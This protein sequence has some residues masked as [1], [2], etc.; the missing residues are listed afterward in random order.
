M[1]LA[2]LSVRTRLIALLGLLSLALFG[3]VLYSWHALALSGDRLTAALKL[4]ND[5]EQAVNLSRKAQVDFKI[6]VQE[7]KDLL[8][9]GGDAQDYDKYSQAFEATA[10]TVTEDFQQLAPLMT[11]I[12]LDTKGIDKAVLEHDL[13]LKKYKDA[14]KSYDRA[15]PARTTTV[16]RMVRGIDR[17]PTGNIDAIV[18]QIRERSDGLSVE[19]VKAAAAE[20]RLQVIW[21]L[22]VAIVA[23]AVSLSLGWYI[24][25]GIVTPLQ[26]ATA[27]AERVA[28]GDLTSHIQPSGS[29]ET[30]RLLQA[31]A[32]M[33]RSLSAM[34]S[35]VRLGANAVTTASTEI[36]A[37]NLDLSSRT[38]QQA[39][40]IEETAASLEELT[41]TVTQNAG[42][43]RE[44]EK[45]AGAA[46]TI[47]NRGGA[48]VNEVVRTMDDIQNSSKKISEIIGVIDS[49]AFQT[50]ILALNAA[51]EAARAGEQGRG[52]AVVATEVRGL[53]Q[54]SAA[55]A[56]EIK[57][58]ITNSVE[59]V[60]NGSRLAG[61]A[62]KTMSEVLE[63]VVQV[64]ALVVDIATA[65]NEQSQGIGQVNIAVQE[66][67]RVT[68]QNASLVEESAAASESLKIQAKRLVETVSIFKVDTHASQQPESEI[69]HSAHR[70]APRPIARTHAA[71]LKRKTP[72]LASL[73]AE[74]FNDS[75]RDR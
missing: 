32:K 75:F 50:N 64:S 73:P 30:A 71:L 53:A 29:D 44:A 28:G 15:D 13:L 38:E 42:N 40:S 57:A 74:S 19:V 47:A 4:A 1:N 6:Q 56:K 8:I 55:A 51:V 14:I 9:R 67:E 54:R 58:L 39:S 35:Q 3:T 66:L 69:S 11:A 62:G 65:T 63:S 10:K 48:V 23:I 20:S 59:A 68:Q 36:A 52:F 37:G 2:D 33:S 21:L 12:G 72:T 49:I 27:L 18:K 26:S 31:L 7:W 43:A 45:L 22:V 17:V 16:D 34:V 25:Q 5:V 70:A 60:D 24:T 46:S 41:S 61:E